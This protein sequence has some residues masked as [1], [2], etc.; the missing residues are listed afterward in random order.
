MF[1]F[2]KSVVKHFR[3]TYP[4]V[5]LEYRWLASFALDLRRSFQ[6]ETM[7]GWRGLDSSLLPLDLVSGCRVSS[8]QTRQGEVIVSAISTILKPRATFVIN[9][10][11]LVPTHAPGNYAKWSSDI[12]MSSN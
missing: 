7:W 12:M 2:I 4:P 6:T 1:I 11:D 5:T 3:Q 8:P 10:V 9:V